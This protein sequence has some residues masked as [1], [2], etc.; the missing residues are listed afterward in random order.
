VHIKYGLL[1]GFAIFC[2]AIAWG[3]TDTAIAIAQ[4]DSATYFNTVNPL[5]V[6]RINERL[7]ADSLVNKLKSDDAFWYAGLAPERDKPDRRASF[8]LWFVQQGWLKSAI[9]LLIVGGFI[10][11]LIWYLAASNI[12]LL[13]K[14]PKNLSD[15]K[16]EAINEDIFSLPYKAEIQKAIAAQ[17][18]RLAT[19]LLYLQTLKQLSERNIIQ[20]QADRTNSTYLSQLY[21]TP[22]YK[23]FFNLTRHFEYVWYGQMQV[24]PTAFAAIQQNFEHFNRQVVL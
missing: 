22:Y 13:K 8:W 12:F 3:Q 16:N 9:W 24:S 21:Q 14:Q 11:V 15:V 19:R 18:F 1:V 7:V 20:Y 5:Q 17:N 6:H 10:A 4:K 2:C 23:D